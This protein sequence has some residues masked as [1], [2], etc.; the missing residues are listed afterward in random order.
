[1]SFNAVQNTF[2]NMLKSLLSFLFFQIVDQINTKL[3]VFFVEKLL[4]PDSH[5]LNL[6]FHQEQEVC[7]GNCLCE[8]RF[9]FS[10]LQING[11]V[12]T[13]SSCGCMAKRPPG[14]N[15]CDIKEIWEKVKKNVQTLQKKTLYIA[16]QNMLFQ[17]LWEAL[18]THVCIY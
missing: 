1:M 3:P 6:R 8:C 7:V 5:L 10:F 4:A 9:M 17:Q 11:S 14:L 15:F 2:C 16:R 13:S 18:Q 12:Q